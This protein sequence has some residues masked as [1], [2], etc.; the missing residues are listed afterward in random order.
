M[1]DKMQNALIVCLVGAALLAAVAFLIGVIHA[2][3]HIW[4]TWLLLVLQVVFAV[5]SVLA[6]YGVAAWL[7]RRVV[8]E[9]SKLR[10][11]HADAL[12]AMKKRASP[13]ISVVLLSTQVLVYVADKPFHDETAPIAVTILLTIT[14][15]VANELIVRPSRSVHIAGIIVWLF[16]V[17][18]L[19]LAVW[20][21]RGFSLRATIAPILELNPV[22][23]FVFALSTFLIIIMPFLMEKIR[24]D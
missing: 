21:N 13:L 3:T 24:E 12:K 22:Y 10:R 23:Q 19:P 8:E 1:G 4:A 6:C 15:F 2:G 14:F 17:C 18:G 7:Y 16:G 9:M 20:V 5:V 11:D